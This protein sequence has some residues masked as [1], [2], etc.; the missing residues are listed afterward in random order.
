MSPPPSSKP[1]LAS[2]LSSPKTVIPVTVAVSLLMLGWAEPSLLPI[3]QFAGVVILLATAGIVLSVW[4]IAPPV[5]VK[6]PGVT[7]A[8]TPAAPAPPPAARV[9]VEQLRQQF[10]KSL[11]AV[12]AT[13]A[14]EVARNGTPAQTAYY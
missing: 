14:Q 11:D 5:G 6:A 7:S 13:T 10:V 12:T 2:L 4:M 1:G 9:T 8:P 3:C